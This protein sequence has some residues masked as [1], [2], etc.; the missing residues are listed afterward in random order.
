MPPETYKE[1]KRRAISPAKKIILKPAA[2]GM[3]YPFFV[4]GTLKINNPLGWLG[5]SKISSTRANSGLFVS[6][7]WNIHV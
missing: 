6:M 3:V 7:T 4:K 2:I 5:H 1:E